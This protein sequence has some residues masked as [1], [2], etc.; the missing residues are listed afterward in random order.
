[1]SNIIKLDAGGVSVLL[2][3]KPQEPP[4]ILYWGA[5]L[6]E[7]T[8]IDECGI[9]SSGL[10]GTW[11]IPLSSVGSW[12]EEPG[13]SGS[14]GG[15]GSSPLFGDFM[16]EHSTSQLTFCSEDTAGRLRLEG[17]VEIEPSGLLALRAKLTNL[18]DVV[19]NLDALTFCLPVPER[20]SE[21]IEETGDWAREHVIQRHAFTYGTHQRII[22]NAQPQDVSSVYG[23]CEPGADWQKGAV[24]LVHVAWSGNTRVEAQSNYQGQR[25][26]RAGEWLAPGEI[27]LAQ[28]EPYETPVV[29]AS[30]GEGLDE[31]AHRFHAHVRALP[32]HPNTPRPVTIN[33]WEAVGFHQ[34]EGKLRKLAEVGQRVGVERFVLDDGWFST[35]RWDDAG[36]GDWWVAKDV[37][38]HGLKPL[39]DYVHELGMQFGI[40]FE[41]E[42]ANVDS[43]IFSAHPEWVLRP[44]GAEGHLPADVRN[45]QVLNLAIP[46][47]FD[48]VLNQMCAVIE[49]VGADYVKWDHNRELWE[50]C[51]TR[52]GLPAYHEQTRACWRLMDAL[53]ER[54]PGLELESCASGGGRIDLGVMER[55]QR[56]WGSD[57]L[58]PQERWHIH[59]GTD[60]LLPPEVVGCHIGKPKSNATGR[61]STLQT[62]AAGSFLYHLGI[63]WDI[64]TLDD[65]ELDRLADWISAYKSCREM[66]EQG[67][68][69]HAFVS[70]A[71]PA[72]R[73][74]VSGDKKQ[75]VY[76][77]FCEE[78]SPYEA[79]Q[80]VRLP[81]LSENL[82]YKV[83]A[84]PGVWQADRWAMRLKTSWWK[85]EKTVELSGALLA[86]VG[87]E[88]PKMNPGTAIA[89][90]CEAV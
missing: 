53:H 45:Q 72:V 31:V 89:L 48:H 43:E 29:Y 74:I 30:T 46:A 70:K 6:P 3:Q 1:M 14:Y 7:I 21:I 50:A 16:V 8:Q 60:L 58:D 17:A 83:G 9:N 22:R 10:V 80:P 27:A 36:L 34:D 28:G 49:E 15:R 5:A 69:V 24:H 4:E 81:G 11:L 73:G 61:I 76:V 85:D 65:E 18:S 71:T 33:T 40:W 23:T 84:L 55:A 20:E 12:N 78:T 56:V 63:E 41:P 39:A 87:L 37:F 86:H 68:L 2:R 51:D 13:L 77:L 75:A 47:C 35:R 90:A 66:L 82:H 64:T 38:P 88:C 79:C 42:S 59:D 32:S 25:F 62:R 19:Y 52:T 44:D 54:F 67:T 26:L 57:D